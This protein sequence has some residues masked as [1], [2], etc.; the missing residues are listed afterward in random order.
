M[1]KID[2]AI[3]WVISFNVIFIFHESNLIHLQKNLI[4]KIGEN[5][6]CLLL[7]ILLIY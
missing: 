5:A 3:F 4:Y 7:E 6:Y 1:Y 2:N